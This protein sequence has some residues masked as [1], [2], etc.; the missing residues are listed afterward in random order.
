MKYVPSSLFSFS[1]VLIFYI[2]LKG[3]SLQLLLS[4]EEN[5]YCQYVFSSEHFKSQQENAAILLYGQAVNYK[6]SDINYHEFE[7]F[8]ED[9]F[10]LHVLVSCLQLLYFNVVSPSSSKVVR[11][12]HGIT[13][14]KKIIVYDVF[15][16]ILAIVSLVGENVIH[17][18]PTEGSRKVV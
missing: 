9:V 7:V 14:P 13:M 11:S 4:F 1:F 18:W 8:S 12:P 16:C 6:E 5:F 3:S 15:V 17:S 2:F 10:N